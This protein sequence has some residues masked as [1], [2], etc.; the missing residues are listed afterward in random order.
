MHGSLQRT[1]HG[2][3]EEHAIGYIT[4]GNKRV[5]EWGTA[6][7]QGGKCA[8]SEYKSVI[9][10]YPNCHANAYFSMGR[11]SLQAWGPYVV[12]EVWT[13]ESCFPEA[14]LS[15]AFSISSH[16]LLPA[17]LRWQL[18]MNKPLPPLNSTEHAR[19]LCSGL[20]H[21][22]GKENTEP[23]TWLLLIVIMHAESFAPCPSSCWLSLRLPTPLLL[24]LF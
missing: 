22:R 9:R 4:K 14:L 24:F 2:T 10:P 19:S 21:K 11:E 6:R 1:Q 16:L 12:A 23:S 5:R 15:F 8:V 3:H 18:A 20:G 7:V 17:G 13:C